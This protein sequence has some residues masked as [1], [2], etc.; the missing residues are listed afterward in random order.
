MRTGL[1][2]FLAR[3]LAVKEEIIEFFRCVA[4]VFQNPLLLLNY[5]TFPFLCKFVL[6][7]EE[8]FLFPDFEVK[9]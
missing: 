2:Y 5:L 9:W 3:A 6:D 4:A 8:Y 1:R 7:P